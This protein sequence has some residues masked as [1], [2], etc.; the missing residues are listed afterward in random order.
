MQKPA[1]LNDAPSF[2]SSRT[3]RFLRVFV[4]VSLL[5]VIINFYALDF[6]SHVQR[7]ASETL[8]RDEHIKIQNKTLDAAS[9]STLGFDS[10]QFINLPGRFD[11]L[12]AATIQAYLSGL[13]ITEVPGVLADD[14]HEAGM[15]PTHRN[16]LK[17]GEKGCW[18]AHAN[19][20]D[21]RTTIEKHCKLT[22]I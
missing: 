18:R 15:P 20:S 19:V 3:Y 1:W 8:N 2:M 7:Q 5:L 13:D 6:R 9:N 14:I 16:E 17:K 10:I 21:F 11:R 22:S 4:G 12:D